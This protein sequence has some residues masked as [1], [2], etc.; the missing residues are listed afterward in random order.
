[1]SLIELEKLSPNIP[2]TKEQS[3]FNNNFK[4][5]GWLSETKA[6]ISQSFL[7]ENINILFN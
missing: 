3:Y 6:R 2:L 5:F 7:E 4:E 1:M